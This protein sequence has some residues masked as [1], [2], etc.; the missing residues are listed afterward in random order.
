MVKVVSDMWYVSL[1]VE[2]S[3][4]LIVILIGRV[5]EC[6]ESKMKEETTDVEAGRS[7]VKTRCGMTPEARYPCPSSL[8]ALVLK[9][10]S[11]I[12]LLMSH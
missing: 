11:G 4:I 9:S 8:I 3:T 12:D 1:E 5:S 2:V 6:V 10:S 7:S